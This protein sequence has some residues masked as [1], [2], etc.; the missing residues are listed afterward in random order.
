[1]V[2]YT[3][4]GAILFTYIEGRT[5]SDL[6]GN[7]IKLRNR[8][9]ASLWELTSKVKDSCRIAQLSTIAPNTRGQRAPSPFPIRI[10][11][12]GSLARK[13]SGMEEKVVMTGDW[14]LGFRR[15]RF[16]VHDDHDDVFAPKYRITDIVRAATAH[17]QH[18]A[19][20][21]L[22]PPRFSNPRLYIYA[23]TACLDMYYL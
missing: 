8:T 15:L 4:A 6:A 2:G 11:S 10:R 21:E 9:A 3:I 12:S 5:S 14:S 1:V 19:D 17:L 16:Q 7:V 18:I 20:V 23:C 13:M 22:N